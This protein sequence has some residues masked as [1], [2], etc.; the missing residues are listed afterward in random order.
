MRVLVAQCFIYPEEKKNSFKF[1]AFPAI[2]KFTSTEKGEWL[3][4]NSYQEMHFEIDNVI[5]SLCKRVRIYAW[6]HD[7]ELTYYRLKWS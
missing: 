3:K 6:L 4:K 2:D 7:V 5:D 1:D